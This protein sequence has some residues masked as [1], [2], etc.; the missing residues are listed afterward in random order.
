M[1]KVRVPAT[2]QF[3]NC[4]WS[5]CGDSA[6]SGEKAY[7]PRV[8]R[9]SSCLN[10]TLKSPTH[11][12]SACAAA[13]SIINADAR[14]LRNQVIYE[15]ECLRLKRAG[16][17]NTYVFRRRGDDISALAI[18]RSRRN[19]TRLEVY[20]F[21]NF[22]KILSFP[23]IKLLFVITLKLY[24]SENETSGD[25]KWSYANVQVLI[26]AVHQNPAIWRK[27]VN[28]EYANQT[29]LMHAWNEVCSS[30]GFDK[31]KSR[32]KWKN[33]RTQYRKELQKEMTR[34]PSGSGAR[35]QIKPWP[36]FQEMSFLRQEIARESSSN[37]VLPPVNDHNND[38]SDEEFDDDEDTDDI[39]FDSEEEQICQRP[40]TSSNLQAPSS[41]Q[42]AS[43]GIRQR[44]LNSSNLQAPSS[45]Q[46]A[47]SCIGQ[48]PSTSSNLQVPSSSQAASDNNIQEAEQR[49]LDSLQPTINLVNKELKLKMRIEIY[50]TLY[51]FLTNNADA[52]T[53]KQNGKRSSCSCGCALAKRMKL[54]NPNALQEP[55]N[56]LAMDDESALP[57]PANAMII[58][59]SALPGPSNATAMDDTALPGPCNAT[60]MDDSALPGPSNATAMDDFALPGP[61]NAQAINDSALAGIG[62]I[63]DDDGLIRVIN[64]GLIRVINPGLKI[65]VI[66]PGLI[67]VKNPGLILVKIR[68][69]S[70]SIPEFNPG[71]TRL[72]VQGQA[73]PLMN[74]LLYVCT[75]LH[76]YECSY[77]VVITAC[78]RRFM[79][80]VHSLSSSELPRQK[81]FIV[82]TCVCVHMCVHIICYDDD[83]DDEPSLLASNY[84]LTKLCYEHNIHTCTCQRDYRKPTIHCK[85]NRT[86]KI[87]SFD[88]LTRSKRQSSVIFE[89]KTASTSSA[90]VSFDDRGTRVANISLIPLG[91]TVSVYLRTIRT[92]DTKI[93]VTSMKLIVV[94]ERTNKFVLL[95]SYLLL[96]YTAHACMAT[97]NM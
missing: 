32:T 23:K 69:Q 13:T 40:S 81:S 63:D 56:T 62:D 20:S 71:I 4:S 88:M 9:S 39:S 74:L 21:D 34:L 67:R 87:C 55:V 5:S 19:L 52:I 42:A 60:A 25:W 92:D 64:P 3:C 70:R 54:E 86:M 16:R 83:D 59:D 73:A 17:W 57:A 2:R 51:H 41:L 75:H 31:D 24:H 14:S 10:Y 1:R 72:V 28:N 18:K 46:A 11:F 85:V 12:S 45:A 48:R 8:S 82:R 78:Y 90:S 66:N 37:I 53:P 36:H 91:T 77:V 84:T 61:S 35:R 94:T 30:T 44:R 26:A 15:S 65:Q 47:S 95:Y 96:T 97:Y 43:S 22:I 6:P 27:D 93:P 38:H 58:D 33:L 50:V 68:V 79:L 49:F 76:T 89:T 29:E 7:M 80:Y